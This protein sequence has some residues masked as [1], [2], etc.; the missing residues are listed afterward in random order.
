[1]QNFAGADLSG[2]L[3]TVWC[4]WVTAS[5]TTSLDISGKK[6]KS[7]EL[8]NV[9]FLDSHPQP[10]W[11]GCL[12]LSIFWSFMFIIYIHIIYS[13]KGFQLYLAGGIEKCKSIPSSQNFI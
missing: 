2:D 7:R 9:M 5:L 12:F 13:V 3:Y 10:P 8:T 11:L 6:E 1:M 4:F